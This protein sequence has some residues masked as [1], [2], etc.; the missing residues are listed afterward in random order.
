MERNLCQHA[1]GRALAYLQWSGVEP[2]ADVCMITLQAVQAALE[3][4]QENLL[5]RVM[6]VLPALFDLRL[7]VHRPPVP[8]AMPAIRRGSMVYGRYR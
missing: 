6:D 8:R 1:L 3:Q 4:G 7:D 5:Q 2:T